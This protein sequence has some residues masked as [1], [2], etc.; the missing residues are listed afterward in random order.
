MTAKSFI[1]A[2]HL[3]ARSIFRWPRNGHDVLPDKSNTE[4]KMNARKLAV[5]H[6]R[7]VEGVLLRHSVPT[8]EVL[9]IGEAYRAGFLRGWALAWYLRLFVLDCSMAAE[10]EWLRF[11]SSRSL[12]CCAAG[13]HFREAFL[14]GWKHWV[15]VSA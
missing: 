6:W 14:H 11:S 8:D 12:A 15:E 3:F 5:D 4:P 2:V 13:E 1:L 10:W 7:Y 9:L